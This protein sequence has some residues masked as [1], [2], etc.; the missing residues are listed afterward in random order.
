[1]V[2][3]KKEDVE[4]DLRT[5]RLDCE[6]L[7]E[8]ARSSS[9][10][11]QQVLGHNSWARFAA[12]ERNAAPTDNSGVTVEGQQTPMGRLKEQALI[13]LDLAEETCNDNP[14]QTSSVAHEIELTRKMLRDMVLYRP[15]SSDEMRAVVAA[16]ANEFQGTG[17]WYRCVNGHPFTVAQCGRPMGTARCPE[18]GATAG[19]QD[20]RA[21]EGVTQ[22]Q[23]IERRFGDLHL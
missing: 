17:H 13:H 1:M 7:I 18:C 8:Q 23:D 6:N 5:N 10:K 3:G 15:V 16:M 12:L 9:Y 19:G 14:S 2:L 21:A 4:V 11:V 20:H 22:A